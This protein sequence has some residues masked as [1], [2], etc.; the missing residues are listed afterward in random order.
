MGPTQRLRRPCFN[1]FKLFCLFFSFALQNVA[2]PLDAFVLHNVLTEA[3]A[4]R[5]VA[6][7]EE[8]AYTF[9]HAEATDDK[10]LFRNADTVIKRKKK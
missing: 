3:E 2:T 10:R 4:A 6:R 9:W 5:L 7:T 8:L 1:C